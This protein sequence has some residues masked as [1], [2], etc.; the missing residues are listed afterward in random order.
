MGVP[1]LDVTSPTIFRDILEAAARL[2]AA[3]QAETQIAHALVRAVRRQQIRA[4]AAA[5]DALL[6]AQ[7]KAGRPCKT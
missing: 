5:H 7:R 6:D 3:R 2:R 4:A 1:A